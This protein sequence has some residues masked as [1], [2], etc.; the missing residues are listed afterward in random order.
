M[1]ARRFAG[2]SLLVLLFTS[3]ALVAAQQPGCDNSVPITARDD[4]FHFKGGNLW[5]EWWTFVR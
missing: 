1:T 2:V 5:M 3:A 4:A